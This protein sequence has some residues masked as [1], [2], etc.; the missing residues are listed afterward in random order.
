MRKWRTIALL[1]IVTL[2]I[3]VTLY[4]MEHRRDEK[5]REAYTTWW[6]Q[7]RAQE[8]SG[9]YTILPNE[10]KDKI[11][12]KTFGDLYAIFKGY[13]CDPTRIDHISANNNSSQ[14]YFKPLTGSVG[15]VVFMKRGTNGWWVQNSIGAWTPPFWD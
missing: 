15:R 9:L 11:D 7:L 1:A 10:E 12:E 13:D 14:I 5:V 8:Y 3:G 2:T 4:F 6:N